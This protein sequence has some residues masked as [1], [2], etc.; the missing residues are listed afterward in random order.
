MRHCVLGQNVIVKEHAGLV[1]TIRIW[2]LTV[3]RRLRVTSLGADI[4]VITLADRKRLIAHVSIV[5]VLVEGGLDRTTK[6]H[7][8]CVAIYRR[9]RTILI[10]AIGTDDDDV[11]AVTI[12]A[13]I[14]S[15]GTGN[16]GAPKSALKVGG[17]RWIG[18]ILSDLALNHHITEKGVTNI[19]VGVEDGITFEI[20]IEGLTTAC[21]VTFRCTTLNV[22]AV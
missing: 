6:F 19:G 5:A 4:W 20:D 13:L 14:S 10:V 18:A 15:L 2:M 3:V 8:T 11:K 7:G 16:C 12:L 22:V 21:L 9:W 17:G 1:T